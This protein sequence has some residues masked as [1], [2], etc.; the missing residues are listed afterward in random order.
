MWKPIIESLSKCYRA[1]AVDVLINT[2]CVGRSV[3]TRAIKSPKGAANWLDEL[4]S[5]LDLGNS[6]NLVGMSYGGWL[7]SQY[8]LHHPDR[9]GKIVLLA[10]AATVLPVRWEL[11]LHAIPLRLLPIRYSYR[12]F[13]HWIFNDLAQKD[14]Q[15]VEVGV[16]ELMT[17][18]RCFKPAEFPNPTI[19]KD[20]ELQSIK[21]PTLFLVGENEVIYS[22]QKA[23]Q[24]L[25]AVAPRIQT[26]VIPRAGHDLAFVQP[27]MVSQKIVEFLAQS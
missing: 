20:E 1:Y 25:N 18:T 17:T 11:T 14:P 23:V 13:C 4:F 15:M 9:L 21:V 3:Y 24:R 6:I 7:T 2:G 22:A 16:T 5:V 10:P 27:E 19:L 26:E 8:V 12:R